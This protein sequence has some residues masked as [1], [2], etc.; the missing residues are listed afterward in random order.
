MYA[1]RVRGAGD[2][3]VQRIGQAGQDGLERTQQLQHAFCVVEVGLQRPKARAALIAG[4]R[5]GDVEPCLDQEFGGKVADLSETEDSDPREAH[6][7]L[8]S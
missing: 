7:S 8:P 1:E 3:A 5:A 6:G 2:L 4:V